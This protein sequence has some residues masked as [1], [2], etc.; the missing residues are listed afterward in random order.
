MEQIREE[1]IVIVGGGIC[2]LATALALHRKGIRSIVLEKSETLR[3]TGVG[4]IMQANGWR[5]LDELGVASV[6]RQTAAFIQS[7]R[8]ISIHDK[9]PKEISL[10]SGER[11]CL[12]RNDLL[13]ALADNLP[14]DTIQFSTQVKSIEMDPITSYPVL[15]LVNGS[16]IEAKIVIGCDGLNSVIAR[17]L[18]L[19]SIAFSPTCVVRGFSHYENG[20]DY[21]NQFLLLSDRNVQLGQV[22]VNDNLIYWFLTRKSTSEDSKIS[23]DKILIKESTMDILKD[24]PEQAIEMIN[25]SEHESLH[26]TGL[27]YRAPWDVLTTNFRKGTVTVGGDAMHAMG[28]FLAQGGSAS[29]EDAVIL[30]RCLAEK[31]QNKAIVKEKVEEGIDKY[32]KQRKMRVFWL[33]LQTYLVGT[34]IQPPNLVMKVLCIFLLIILFRDP[35]KHTDYDCREP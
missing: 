7:C 27:R 4:I 34:V 11:R 31:I 16:V 33:C 13:K 32:L 12:K 15:C 14:A 20:H 19:N 2:G 9:K 22:P 23:R 17:I 29:L 6:L 24:F 5:A 28:P 10:G 18:G 21:A 25:K 1:D 26:L 3:A 35:N 8:Q 30:A